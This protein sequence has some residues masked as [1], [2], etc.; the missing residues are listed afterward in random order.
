MK[1]KIGGR[2]VTKLEVSDFNY[3]I[4]L[5]NLEDKSFRGSK[6]TW[7]NGRTY[8]ECIFKRQ[9]KE[10]YNDQL[11]NI[12]PVS[13]VEHPIWSG[14]DHMPLSI[15]FK[16]TNEKVVKSF[17]FLNFGH[18]EDSFMEVVRNHWKA[19]FESDLFNVSSY[20][21]SVKRALMQWSKYTFSIIFQEIVTE[22]E[23]VIRVQEVEFETNP[24]R[25]NLEMLHKAHVDVKNLHREEEF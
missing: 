1:R 18:K 14:S 10:L 6:Y 22:V 7:W 13:E 9:D 15:T 20:T 17:R 5:G 3:C 2:P 25:F 24:P 12:F 16:A 21:K 4:K 23:E 8:D 19:Y 11:H